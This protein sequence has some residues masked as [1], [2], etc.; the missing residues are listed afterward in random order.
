MKKIIQLTLVCASIGIL[1]LSG[2]SCSTEYDAAPGVP[3]RDTMKNYMRGDFTALIG[4]EN[5]IADMKYVSDT[6]DEN[7]IRSINITGI[8]YSFDKNPKNFQT[9][10]LSI[11]DYKGPGVYPIQLGTAGTYIR[12]DENV[13]TQYLAK[14]GDTLALIQITQDRGNMVG[15]FNFVVAPNGIGEQDNHAITNGAFNVPK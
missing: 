6:K 8:M 11:S 15:T 4:T 12:T 7:D 9:I 14:T 3:G 1:W 2:A 13:P 5:Y 10:S